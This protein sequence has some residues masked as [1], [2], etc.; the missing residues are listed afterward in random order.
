MDFQTY[1][2][3][4]QSHV[5][6]TSSDDDVLYRLMIWFFTI[7]E[8][9]MREREL[10]THGLNSI[11]LNSCS[12]SAH[13]SMFIKKQL[14]NL[15]KTDH[16]CGKNAHLEQLNSMFTFPIHW[17]SICGLK[18]QNSLLNCS[19]YNFSI[20]CILKEARRHAPQPPRAKI[21][22]TNGSL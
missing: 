11:K 3:E 1:F 2:F 16:N 12:N 13:K 17:Y 8:W 18:S 9:N 5:D 14:S 15:L 6:A 20:I 7:V 22:L 4:P 10:K 21:L 19:F